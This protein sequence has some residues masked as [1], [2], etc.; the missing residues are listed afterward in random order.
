MGSKCFTA[1]NNCRLPMWPRDVR[2]PCAQRAPSRIVVWDGE[3]FEHAAK[4]PVNL[5]W[6]SATWSHRTTGSA[7]EIGQI[8]HV[9]GA[10]LCMIAGILKKLTDVL[11]TARQL[12]V[13]IAVTSLTYDNLV[14]PLL[15]VVT[16]A[17]ARR[18]Q[19]VLISELMESGRGNACFPPH[20]LTITT[21]AYTFCTLY[22]MRDSGDL[23]MHELVGDKH[24]LGDLNCFVSSPATAAAQK[25]GDKWLAEAQKPQFSTSGRQFARTASKRRTGWRSSTARRS[26]R[27]ARRGG[28]FL[29]SS[30]WRR[31]GDS[32][33][34]CSR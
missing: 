27:A 13:H 25:A 11:R 17:N 2:I 4:G 33:R 18:S 15:S 7:V 21:D 28:A 10:G 30:W 8:D 5:E 23:F 32:R 31:R 19:E 3:R 14:L 12:C 16:P 1:G 29:N 6:L 34:S 20:S 24:K 9:N 22:K 26:R